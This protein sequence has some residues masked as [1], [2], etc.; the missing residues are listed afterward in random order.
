MKRFFDSLPIRWKIILTVIIPLILSL[1]FSIDNILDSNQVANKLNKIATMSEIAVKSSEL[2]HELQKERGRTAGFLNSKG[3][4]FSLEIKNQREETNI[5]LNKYKT[6]IENKEIDDVT[7]SLSAEMSKVNQFLSQL[8]SNRESIDKF[9]INTETALKYY[10]QTINSLIAI[11][12]KIANEAGENAEISRMI[13]SY[14]SYLELKERNGILRA[15]MTAVFAKNMFTDFLYKRAVEITSEMNVY[16]SEFRIKAS[17]EILNYEK[18]KLQG[19]EVEQSAKFYEFAIQN[20]DSTNFGI[21]ADKWFAVI[22]KKIDLMKEVED[23]ISQSILSKATDY[24]G[25]AKWNRNF[26]IILLFVILS[27]SFLLVFIITKR[28]SSRLALAT[29]IARRISKGDLDSL[30]KLNIT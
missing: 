12:D 25:K 18:S 3:V 16:N 2:V 30:S 24:S 5:F 14:K 26:L 8:N 20:H 11:V 28:I 6:G 10:T 21:S 29:D 4:K 7:K 23:K 27:I 19:E 17:Q 22:T 9:E 15:T 13:Y 1:Y